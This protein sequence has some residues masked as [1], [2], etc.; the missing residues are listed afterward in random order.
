MAVVDVPDGPGIV[1]SSETTGIEVT[2]V[3]VA[4]SLPL[5]SDGEDVTLEPPEEE[6]ESGSLVT[7]DPVGVE[8]SPCKVPDSAVSICNEVLEEM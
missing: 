4:Q 6:G 2:D 1:V 7:D 3:H 8:L 5:A